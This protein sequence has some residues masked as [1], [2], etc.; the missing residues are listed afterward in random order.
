VSLRNV[1]S[2]LEHVYANRFQI[3]FDKCD[4]SCL[5]RIK[6]IFKKNYRIFLEGN[7]KLIFLNK[8]IIIYKNGS[9]YYK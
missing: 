2:Q 6:Q 1:A 9:L 7:F 3:I 8:N 4:F 5:V